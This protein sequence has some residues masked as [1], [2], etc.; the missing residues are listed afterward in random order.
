MV[1]EHRPTRLAVPLRID[2]S[3]D[4]S[5]RRESPLSRSQLS[6]GSPKSSQLTIRGAILEH[7]APCEDE[8]SNRD[9]ISEMLEDF[10]T[11][12]VQTPLATSAENTTPI[13]SLAKACRS[14]TTTPATI[15]KMVEETRTHGEMLPVMDWAGMSAP[16]RSWRED[17]EVLLVAIY[18]RQDTELSDEDVACVDAIARSLRNEEAQWLMRIFKDEAEIF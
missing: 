11:P 2:R 13:S 6:R 7:S 10:P 5:P 14:S 9:S 15:R 16:E 12:P 4:L 18:G 17:N 8:S 3:L 1:R